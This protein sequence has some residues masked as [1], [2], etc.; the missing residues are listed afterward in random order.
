[1]GLFLTATT[2]I[3]YLISASLVAS[4][5]IL[6]L[7]SFEFLVYRLQVI[8]SHIC[9]RFSRTELISVGGFRRRKQADLLRI[10]HLLNDFCQQFDSSISFY[11]FGLYIFFFVLPFFLLF[12]GNE[13][14]IRLLLAFVAMVTYMFCFLFS[15]CNDR[16]RRRVLRHFLYTAQS[17]S[18]PTNRLFGFFSDQSPGE[19]HILHSAT[20]PVS[21]SQ[22]LVR[23]L[24]L[25][26]Q[27]TSKRNFSN[28]VRNCLRLERLLGGR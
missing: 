25:D 7:L 3:A 28:H 24:S 12:A 16:L 22:N 23:Q 27:R 5:F 19:Q 14:S 17:G 6:A 13:P 15:I 20:F 8:N 11:L 18:C 21:N 4:R 26:E 2:I 1:M 10:I 9:K